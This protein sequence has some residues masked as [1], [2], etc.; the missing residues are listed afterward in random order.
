MPLE[1]Q[2]R[3]S[4]PH[5]IWIEAIAVLEQRKARRDRV[6]SNGSPLLL[7]NQNQ[8]GDPT[9]NTIKALV[10]DSF[11]ENLNPVQPPDQETDSNEIQEETRQGIPI[12]G[13]KEAITSDPLLQ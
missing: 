2:R 3:V 8:T 6:I 10:Q 11:T 5:V 4:D 9:P 13:L 1:G 7:S 12:N